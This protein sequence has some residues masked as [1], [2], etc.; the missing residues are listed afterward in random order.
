MSDVGQW[1]RTWE[2]LLVVSVQVLT[3]RSWALCLSV[4]F[5]AP[6]LSSHSKALW[7]SVSCCS[8]AYNAACSPFWFGI[9]WASFGNLWGPWALGSLFYQ[10]ISNS[11][12]LHLFLSLFFALLLFV[13]LFSL[14]W[15]S[16]LLSS[17]RR[18]SRDHGTAHLIPPCLPCWSFTSL[19][20][21]SS[22]SSAPSTCLLT[23]PRSFTFTK[24][25]M[26]STLVFI[27]V[28]SC[29]H[30]Q[31]PFLFWNLLNHTSREVPCTVTS[32]VDFVYLNASDVK[33][34]TTD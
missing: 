22:L 28:E 14:L 19:Y 32:S 16:Q 15:I 6:L 29:P 26:A 11:R 1:L 18:C 7:R 4:Y 3:A 2:L 27:P 33:T 25:S 24:G 12:S 31:F 17:V 5:W 9:S 8:S 34:P 23:L 10:L 20:S 13:C 30:D 21:F